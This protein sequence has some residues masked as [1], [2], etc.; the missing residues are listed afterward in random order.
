MYPD[1]KNA[2]D[3]D[4]DA[5]QLI[6]DAMLIEGIPSHTGDHAAGV[7]IADK[8][9]TEYAPMLWNEKKGVWVIQ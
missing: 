1:F 2:Y 7:I 5:K 6:N 4:P 3:T 9:I 8:P